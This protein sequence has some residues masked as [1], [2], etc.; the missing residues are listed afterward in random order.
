MDKDELFKEID[1]IQACIE[2]MSKNSF[3]L[4]GWALTIFAGVCAFLKMEV[5]NNTWLL[6]ST[7]AIPFFC[8]WLLDAYFVQTERK[9]RKL[10][11]WV[12]RER[13]A[14]NEELQY[15]LNPQRFKKD[16]GCLCQTMFSKTL[17][18]FYGIPMVVVLLYLIIPLINCLCC[19][20]K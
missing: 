13:K 12:I 2:R 14:G 8:F 19:N 11:E 18:F 10:Y 9:Y 20:C 3:M 1:L 15:D 5:L 7:V 16:V 4:K 6:L 17:V